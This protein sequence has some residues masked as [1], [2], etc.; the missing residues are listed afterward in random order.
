MTEY[1]LDDATVGAFFRELELIET[2]VQQVEYADLPFA[3]GKIVPLD[4]QNKPAKTSV[5][6][7][8]T[9]KLGSFAL[10]RNY[11]SALPMIEVLSE[12]FTQKVYKYAGG[13]WYS[14]DDILTASETG[15]DIESEKVSGVKEASEQLLNT[16]IA[17]GDSRIGMHG[18]LNDPNILYSYAPY[19][20]DSNSE[21]FQILALLHDT[22]TAVVKLTKQIE[23]PDTLILPV[24]QF[25]YLTTTMISDKL[26][27]TLMEWFLKSSPY[28]KNVESINELAGAGD[29]G[30]D[31]MK[32]YRRDRSKVKFR[33]TQ[34][35][36][37]LQMTRKGLGYERPA[38]LKAGGIVSYRPYSRHAV[39]GI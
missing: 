18:F 1:R 14:D 33:I 11:S 4:I 26:Q 13:Y 10:Q 20:I 12:E 6:Y 19:T 21:T 23:K 38:V 7:R 5:T 24:D 36:T 25:H 29:G 16:L 27:L 30:T 39:S 22:V 35:L 3:S 37:F 15:W 17:F 2:E 9:S 32:V 8:Q 28:I 31:M 34:P